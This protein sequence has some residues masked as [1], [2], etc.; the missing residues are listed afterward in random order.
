MIKL[1][2]NVYNLASADW[3]DTMRASLEHH[4]RLERIANEYEQDTGVHIRPICLVQVERTG[5]KQRGAGFIHAEEVRDFLTTKCAVPP[6]HVAVKSS[7][8]DEME[9][10]PAQP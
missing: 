5:Q 3:R 9:H 6:E 1:D 2:I 4:E 7:E 10:Q 8:Q